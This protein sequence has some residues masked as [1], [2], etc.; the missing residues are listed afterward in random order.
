VVR[1]GRVVEGSERG[2]QEEKNASNLVDTNRNVVHNL[3]SLLL[4][5][6]RKTEVDV[7]N[8]LRCAL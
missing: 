4:M 1:L 2:W 5:Q 7:V 3:V 6:R 8:V